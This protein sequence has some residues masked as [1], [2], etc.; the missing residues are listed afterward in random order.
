MLLV[1]PL[2]SFSVLLWGVYLAESWKRK[3][4]GIRVN[5][6]MSRFEKKAVPR[7][8]FHGYK[9]VSSV[10]GKIEEVY[11]SKAAHMCKIIFSWTTVF[12]CLACVL[13]G[14]VGFLYWEINSA[15]TVTMKIIRGSV[16][17]IQIMIFNLAYYYISE[18]LNTFEKP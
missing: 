16:N 13:S 18:Y 4:A 2:L 14:L 5:W 7:P 1:L 6:G 12:F 9:V 11:E 10:T 3:E 15:D 17:A 8:A